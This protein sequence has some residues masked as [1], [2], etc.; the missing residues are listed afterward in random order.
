MN[1]GKVQREIP[2]YLAG[3]TKVCDREAIAAHL[4]ECSDCREAAR[5]F[6]AVDSLL[7]I[8]DVPIPPP[9][10][11]VPL[12][13]LEMDRERLSSADSVSVSA[14][15]LAGPQAGPNTTGQA[16]PNTTGQSK[17]QP[18][19]QAE[20]DTTMQAWPQAGPD[21]TRQ[22]GPQPKPSPTRH[23][24]QLSKRRRTLLLLR[25]LAVSAAASLLFAWAGASAP[26]NLAGTSGPVN[27]PGASA[28][29]SDWAGASARL[30]QGPNQFSMAI[31][32]FFQ[33]YVRASAAATGRVVDSL[34]QLQ[35]TIQ[36][37]GKAR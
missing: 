30:E 7:D 16:G 11:S 36:R 14:G 34:D 22:A 18:E 23:S 21:T 26:S 1:C 15:R 5:Q 28:P 8:W 33:S 29:L 10:W 12:P 37:G 3:E 35:I 24:K 32:G 17:W 13:W 31:S 19:Q 25:D 27:L 9:E 2:A 6:Q 4:A 20:P